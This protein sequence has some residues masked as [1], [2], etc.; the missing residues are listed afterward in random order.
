MVSRYLKWC[1]R[2]RR[3]LAAGAVALF[4]VGVALAS[5]LELRTAF[6]ELLPTDDP[7]VVTLAKTQKQ[8]GDLS[9]LLIGI[10]SPDREA[11]L[12]YA[13]ILT[14]KLRSLPRGICELASFHIRDMQTFVR[15]NR[16][17]YVSE[18]DL[19]AIRDRIR[20]EISKRKNPLFVD[21]GD[22]EESLDDL[23]TRI[24]TKGAL[25]GRFADGYF[26]EAKGQYVWIA[27][28]P[29]GGLFGEHAGETLLKAAQDLIAAN[30][31]ERQ[32]PGMRVHVGG[33][34]VTALANRRAV[35]QDILWVTVTCIAVVIASLIFYFRRLGA[36]PLVGIPAVLGTVLAFAF[37]KLAFG[38]LNSSTAFLGSIILGNGINYAIVLIARY[39]EEKHR[40][41]STM[42]ALTTAVGG[43]WRPTLVAACCA[44][45][46]YLSLMVTSFRGFSQFGAMGGVGCLFSW[47]ATFVVLPAL[48][49]IVDRE[50][51]ASRP[52]RGPVRLGWL[53][54]L[55]RRR[56]RALL[57][58]S[59]VVT[60]AAIVTS[61]HF[62]H[63][64][65]EY[66]FRRLSTRLSSTDEAKKFQQNMDGLFGRWP[67]PTVIIVP[68]TDDAEKAVAAIRRQDEVQ[69]GPP[70]IGQIVTVHDLLPGTPAVQE[71]KL[72]VLRQIRKLVVDPALAVLNEQEKKQLTEATPPDTLKV[73][74]PADLPALV[75]R[76]F[77]EVDGQ[78]G[79]VVLVYPVEERLSVWNG[80]D[81]LRLASVLQHLRLDDGRVV[82]TSGSA[83]IFGAMIRSILHDGPVATISAA[84]AIFV[85]VLL[86]MRPRRFALLALGALAIG[87]LWM[88]G[89]AGWWGVKVTFLN[90]IALP[91]T[92]GIGVEY[93]VNVMARYQEGKDP[94]EAVS[95]TGGAVALCSWTTIVGYGSLLAAQN[96]ALR[97]FGSM[98][99][100]GEVSCLVAGIVTLPAFLAL[101][102]RPT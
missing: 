69:P 96:Q 92:F 44:S 78:I 50:G 55:V 6:S 20:N 91:I 82:D 85:I 75:R 61:R 32:H 41:A 51:S 71:R 95:S 46:A 31:P 65:F 77:T 39:E 45:A 73:L 86:T 38:Y 62:L 81:L 33:P 18:P 94:A 54:G 102:R 93:A 66:D 83:V 49:L 84:L 52:R 101:T 14:Q 68:R 11:N 19:E 48:I 36:V 56:H 58:G 37:A 5:K 90:F 27:A 1:A 76:P 100:L 28:L 40:T 13:E 22:D 26:A 35:E 98:A 4:V 7:G 23:K 30:P 63:D 88:V 24:A 42:A 59:L 2:R 8:M 25:P 3:S 34:I 21:L 17:L 47:A 12:R 89:A 29:P 87:V 80:R 64:P 16:W 9:L 43:V 57:V 10:S 74:Q 53:G 72:G 67:S 99:I 97:G 60:T 70:V 79:R 15:N